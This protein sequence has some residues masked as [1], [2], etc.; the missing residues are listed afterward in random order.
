MALVHLDT[1]QADTIASPHRRPNTPFQKMDRVPQASVRA[2]TTALKAPPKSMRCSRHKPLKKSI[3]ARPDTVRA[4]ITASRLL[5][6]NMPSLKINR[7]RPDTVR[8]GTTVW[9]PTPQNTPFTKMA[10][11]RLGTVQVDTTA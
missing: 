6:P 2:D 11:A 4:E 3:R 1:A 9:R 7:V 5:P 10:L 8:A